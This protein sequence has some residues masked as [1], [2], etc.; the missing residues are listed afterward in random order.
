MQT[1]TLGVFMAAMLAS[2]SLAPR[3]ADAQE[4]DL[5]NT[6]SRP[7]PGD[8]HILAG[9]ERRRSCLEGGAFTCYSIAAGRFNANGSLDPSFGDGGVARIPIWGR[10]EYVTAMEIQPDGKILIV[11]WGYDPA[12]Y[13][14]GRYAALAEHSYYAVF[15]LDASGKPDRTFNRSGRLILHFGEIVPGAEDTTPLSP[16]RIDVLDSGKIL[17][18]DV[19]YPL[20]PQEMALIGSDGT[21]DTTFIGQP[22]ALAQVVDFVTLIEFRSA[23]DQYFLASDPEEFGILDL[24]AS[25]GW[26]RTG[27]GIH[28]YPASA[29]RGVP[30]CRLYG[31]PWLG[32]GGHFFTADMDECMA[33]AGDP[34][35]AWILESRE[36]FRVEIPDRTN[37]ECAVP[38][39]RIYRLLAQRTDSAHRFAASLDVRD[40]AL[41]HGFV[42]EGYGANNVAM[43]G[44][45]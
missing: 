26:S 27:Y 22:G 24:Q 31:Q 44:P 3:A 4:V 8:K 16:H 34:S 2:L 12:Q 35:G 38:S 17:L 6:L 37:G 42:A 14:T 40:G 25:P 5:I 39:T 29:T 28:V 32:L 18:S 33:L 41:A 11:A 15:R 19:S 9:S 21:L 23:R 1:I 10:Y 43:C 7:V 13:E 30:V 45:I 20:L 36:A